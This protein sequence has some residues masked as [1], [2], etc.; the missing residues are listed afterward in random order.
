VETELRGQVQWVHQLLQVGLEIIESA[1]LVELE[2]K[3]V[4]IQIKLI[5]LILLIREKL[6]LEAKII[7]NS[8]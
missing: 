4:L 6:Q 2:I 5:C 8:K 7:N 3:T 1:L